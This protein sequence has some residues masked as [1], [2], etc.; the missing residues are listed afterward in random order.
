MESGAGVFVTSTV[1]TLRST[2]ATSSKMS[3]QNI[4]SYYRNFPDFLGVRT[5]RSRRTMWAKYRKNKLVQT[6]FE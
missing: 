6:V 4:A 3:T 5:S 2:T 1:G